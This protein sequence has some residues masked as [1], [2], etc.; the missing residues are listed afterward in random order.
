MLIRKKPSLSIV[1]QKNEKKIYA[2]EVPEKSIA[3]LI[4][5]FNKVPQKLEWKNFKFK[6]TAMET[7][8]RTGFTKQQTFITVTSQ[9]VKI[10]TE[11]SQ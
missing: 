10:N 8:K 11:K 2:L 7:L 3:R 4:K 5:S 9:F 6:L 1:L